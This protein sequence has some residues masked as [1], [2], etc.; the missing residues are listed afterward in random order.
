L[1]IRNLKIAIFYDWL[2]QWGGAEKVLLDILKIF[3]KSPVF[4]LIYNPQKTNWLPKETQVVPSLINKLPSSK[5]NSIFYT[6][7]YGLALEQFD[8]S[9]YDIVISTTQVSG[10]YLL[11]Q[12]KTLF[13]CYLHNVNRYLYQTPPQFKFLRPLLN[14]YQKTDFIYGQ[15]PDHLLCN[16]QTV[17][18][19]I[20]SAYNRTATVIYPGVDTDFFTPGDKNNQEPYFLLV[21]RLVLHKRID[22]AI[23]ACNQLNKKLIIVG[24]GRDKDKLIKIRNQ[25]SKS[26]VIFFGHVSDKKLLF[27]YQN[28]QALICPQIEDYGISPLEAQA[29]GKPVIAYNQGGITET[30]INGKTGIFFEKQSEESLSQAIKKFNPQD[31]SIQTC[32]DNAKRFSRQNF[33]LNFKQTIDNLWQ[34]HQTTLS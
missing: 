21:S 14:H 18:H 20:K 5:K 34:Q 8:F 23:K 9:Q 17:K 25:N 11:T 12:P 31:F 16:S 15:R 19:R 22:I 32:V 24:E 33:M 2:N 30:I 13:I 26:N 1:D 28:C 6:P 29:C 27:L 10:H 3:P 7:F 4:T